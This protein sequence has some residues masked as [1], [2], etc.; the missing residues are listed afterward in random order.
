MSSRR[1][2]PLACFALGLAVILSGDMPTVTGQDK[3]PLV[4][5]VAPQS[6]TLTTPASLGAKP[7]ATV[8]LTLTGTNLTDATSV[9]LSGN[10]SGTVVEDKKPDAGKTKVKIEVPAKTAIGL[11]TIRVGTKH[12]VSNLRPF[13]VDDLP[14]VA[15]VET[16]RTKDGA[17]P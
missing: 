13:V 5:P 17:Q 7:G 15:E 10:L 16:N 14:E 6:P 2:V 8:E 1:I 3:K 4:V 9:L 12:G 11:Y